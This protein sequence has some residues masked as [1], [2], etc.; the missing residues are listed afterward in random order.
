[1][2]IACGRDSFGNC[3]RVF[4]LLPS[5]FKTLS[6]CS[7]FAHSL[8]DVTTANVPSSNSPNRK[9]AS[10]P[11]ETPC[12]KVEPLYVID[13]SDPSDPKIAGELE[14]PGF[15]EYLHP[16]GEDLLIGIGKGAVTG[17]SGTTWFQGIKI[18]LFDVSD[19]SSPT[20]LDVIDIG[21]RGSSTAL[22]YDH[23]A[24]TGLTKGDDYRFALPISVNDNT[25][26]GDYWKDPESAYY[27]WSYTGL[28]LFDVKNKKLSLQGALITQSHDSET[29]EN[30]WT[31]KRG[32][33][34]GNDVYHLS[35]SDIYKANW[36]TPDDISDKF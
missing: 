11:P 20:E 10:S 26:T 32:L 1:M 5:D 19:M 28:H 14:I 9:L 25:P 13:L 24:F 3:E 4:S 18:A 8:V 15:S 7:G 23:H 17:D 2:P 27:D 30:H 21:Q 6:K 12:N 29:T 35:G 33:I 34:Q 36:L 16:I 31:T 22:S